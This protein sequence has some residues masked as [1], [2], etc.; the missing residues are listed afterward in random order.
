MADP[1]S[2]SASIAG[3]V[4]LADLVFRSGTKY[5]KSYRG[6]QKEVEGLLRKIRDLSVVLHSLSLVAFDLEEAE[7]PEKNVS[8]QRKTSLQPHHL[9][10][11]HQLLRRLETNLSRTGASMTSDS[12]MERLQARLKWPFTSTESKD[13]IL[14]I[15]R[16]KHIIDIAL[17]SD[18]LAKLNICLSRQSEIKDSLGEVQRITEKILD[19]QVKIALDAKR[20]KVLKDFGRVNPRQEYDTNR[21][22][23]HGLTGL[24]LT[25]GS[26]FGHWYSTPGSRIWC[27]GIP[28]AEKSVLAAAIVQECLQR[29]ADDVSMAVA[30]F[31]CT[32]RSELS[33]QPSS[34]LSSLCMQLA[35]QNENAFE[36]L[37]QYHDELYSSPHLSTEPTTD[38]LIE[39]IGRLC[40]CFRQVHIVVDGLDE[41]G[42]QAGSSV[43]CLAKLGLSAGGK[44][45][46]LAL[47][48]R[49]EI[50]IR[51]EVEDDFSHI[52]IE[53]QTADIQLYV[54][55]ELS[56]RIAS[57]KLRLRDPSLKDLI[58]TRLVDEAKGMFRWV[59]CQIDHTCELPTDKARREALDKLPP[60]LFATYDRILMRIEGYS[61]SVK[62]LVKKALKLLFFNRPEIGLKGLCE[63]IS[64]NENS[65]TLECDEI[66]DEEDLLQWCSSFVRA[67]TTPRRHRD[68]VTIEFAHFT[69]REYFG[70]LGT[71]YFD[72]ASAKLKD[73]GVSLEESKEL[74]ACSYMRC[75]NMNNVERLPRVGN[76]TPMIENLIRQRR[77]SELYC[78]AVVALRS[79]ITRGT[80]PTSK[81][82]GLLQELFQPCKNTSFCLWAID[83]VSCCNNCEPDRDSFEQSP[84][85]ET[86]HAILRPEFST[87]HLAAAFGLHDICKWL[88]EIGSDA[89]LCSRFGT[90]LDCA[91]GGLGIF[92]ETGFLH[93]LQDRYLPSPARTQTVQ[94]LIQAT[95]S[96][97]PQIDTIYR[98]E[99][100]ASFALK[101]ASPFNQNLEV[102]MH[103]V[104]AG[105]D[106]SLSTQA[107]K[108]L[109]D[110]FRFNLQER[111]RNPSSSAEKELFSN[112]LEVLNSQETPNKTVRFFHQ[113]IQPFV[114]GT[115][116]RCSLPDLSNMPD[117]Q[118]LGYIFSLI[119]LNNAEGMDKFLSTS[120]FELVKSGGIDPSHQD[121]SA[122]HLAVTY[123]SDSVLRKLLDFGLEA[124]TGTTFGRTPVHLCGLEDNSQSLRTLLQYGGTT[125][126]KDMFN[127]TVWHYA[128]EKSSLLVLKALLSS[129]EREAGLRTLSHSR[130]SPICAAVS[131]SQLRSV[132]YLLHCCETHEYWKH[133]E[134]LHKVLRDPMFGKV[135]KRLFARGIFTDT[136]YGL[137]I[138]TESLQQAI[139]DDDVNH[140]R[141]I[142]TLGFP[143]EPDFD[144]RPRTPLSL[145]ICHNAFNVVEYLLA[146]GLYVSTIIFHP[147]TLHVCTAFEMALE[148]PHFN[149]YVPSF[150][151]KYIVEGGNF[152]HMQSSLLSIPLLTGNSEGLTILLRELKCISQRRNMF[153]NIPFEEQKAQ[154]DI[155]AAMINQPDK[156]RQ[157]QT[158]LHI[159]AG[160][161]D[162]RGTRELIEYGAYIDVYDSQHKTPLFIAVEKG[163][164]DVAEFLLDHG[165]QL[166]VRSTANETILEVAFANGNWELASFLLEFKAANIR[167]GP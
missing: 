19:I 157:Y 101:D 6:A 88:L 4:A 139:E 23:R 150:L 144:L 91:V 33:Q 130:K 126:D 158:P 34:I 99:N 31:F 136:A 111:L 109:Q 39:I 63:A 84:R 37:Q 22:L 76:I 106:I 30:Y 9:H 38:K 74:V 53:A 145:A 129:S 44:L 57:R 62:H 162:L 127:K 27:S 75:I 25:Q 108:E 43:K 110:H 35:M 151:A 124:R 61:D 56:E 165:A 7:P 41:C 122:L 138:L 5:A 86:I 103:L 64:L 69:V 131:K 47:L 65:N 73:Y 52:E 58:M 40:D 96:R 104:K 48:S 115:V 66:V 156:R 93:S 46:S 77:C 8:L 164:Q 154:V 125:L 133:K 118:V 105:F 159:S 72:H 70:T 97:K 55:S 147:E 95:A 83:Y 146:K 134:S 92:K 81:A 78:Y 24:W 89:E 152:S 87:L 13:M 140:C 85:N 1:L 102:V 49:N 98:S 112:L 119:K 107:M 161:N 10:D 20:D 71:R 2:I 116:P 148:Q 143:R 128:A 11:C 167:Y 121:F 135:C 79:H 14:E 17:A 94:L 137:G 29:N 45:I 21:S 132:K 60:T 68:L 42:G 141:K 153:K 114:H 90:P 123:Q 3:L 142:Y 82:W 28:G 51:Q 117:E 12:G 80:E 163:C 67:K 59:A 54:A 26:E 113:E 32:Y 155:L 36:A 166:D 160:K 149:N 18:T 16:Y 50:E 15:Q 100:I 120:R